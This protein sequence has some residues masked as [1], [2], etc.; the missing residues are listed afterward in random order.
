MKSWNICLAVI[1]L[2]VGL[3]G[4]GE[5]PNT[6]GGTV[7]GAVAGGLIGSQFGGGS[8]K[9]A[10][11]IAGAAV[12]GY[13]GNRVGSYMD[14]QD[15]INYSRA[16]VN[17]PVGSEASWTNQQTHATYTVR[18]VKQ[19]HSGSR[20]CRRYSTTVVMNGRPKQAYGTACKDHNGNWKIQG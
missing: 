1:G 14:R 2:S 5:N 17:T 3:A 15:R 6:T 13:V 4:C 12:G 7:L 20:V 9:I 18:P 16:V 19:Y 10:A 8:G 11:T